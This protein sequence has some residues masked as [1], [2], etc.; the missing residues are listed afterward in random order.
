MTADQPLRIALYSG[1]YVQRD[2]VSNSVAAKLRVLRNLI[3]QGAPLEVTVFTQ[4]SDVGDPEVTVCPTFSH[5]LRD[6]RFWSSDLHIFESG[7]Y[8]D[9]Y[10]A[11]YLVP[12]D[13]PVLAIE[14]NTTPPELVDDPE[15]KAG[16][17]RALVQRSN[18]TLARHVACVSEFNLEVARSVGV[19]ED[20]LSVLHLPAS[21]VP[22]TPPRRIGSGGGPV[23]LLAVGRFVRAKGIGDLLSLVRRLRT[24]SIPITLTLAGDPRFSDPAVL[25]AVE[26]ARAEL[27]GTLEVVLAPDDQTVARLY[28]ESDALVVASYHEGYCVPVVEAYGFGRFVIAYDAGNLSFV[29]GGLG[30]LV[31]TGDVDALTTAVAT[32]ADGVRVARGGGSLTLPTESGDLSEAKWLAGV[33]RHLEGY[34]WSRFEEGFVSILRDLIGVDRFASLNAG[35]APLVQQVGT[36]TKPSSE[37]YS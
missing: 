27:D 11:I 2:A 5:L 1:L 13:R 37:R 31:P 15:A 23:R 8:Y 32:F 25:G 19:P 28:A 6:D 20:R 4:G 3:D 33:N 7:M 35:I 30:A 10:N 24:G 34:G 26:K 22:G 9:L 21:I 12:P 18:L 17:E 16:C 14:H 36:V 29:M